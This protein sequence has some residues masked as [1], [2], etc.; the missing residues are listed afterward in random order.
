MK[1]YSYIDSPEMASVRS[2][3]RI[4]A[5][6]ISGMYVIAYNLIFLF[7]SPDKSLLQLIGV[8]ASYIFLAFAGFFHR[9]TS[10]PLLALIALQITSLNLTFFGPNQDVSATGSTAIFLSAVFGIT[11]LNKKWVPAWIALNVI[12]LTFLVIKIGI[13]TQYFGAE[14][15]LRTFSVVQLIVVAVWFHISWFRQ[16]EYVKARDALNRRMADS[17]ESALELQERTRKWRE[18]LVHT[19]ET[20]LNDIRSVI[21][22][23]D[24]DFDELKKQ[25]INRK[26]HTPRPQTTETNFSDLM[27]EVQEYVSLQID[28]NITGAGTEIPHNVYVALRSVIVELCRNFERHANATKITSKASLIYGILRIELFHNGKDSTTTFDTGIGQGIVI[29]ETLDEINAK[30]FRRISGVE[31][32]VALNMRQASSRTLGST[33]LGRISVSSVTVGNAV[34]G[35]LFSLSLL[36]HAFLGEQ[37]AGLCTL[38]LALFAAVVNWKR[39]PINRTYIIG[40]ALVSIIQAIATFNSISET[41]SIDL[42]AIN[43]VLAGFAVISIL[44]W[45]D[46]VKLWVAGLPW[47]IGLIAFRTQIDAETSGTAISSLNTGYG[48]PAF[49]AA[50]VFGIIRGNQRLKETE[51]LSELEIKERV[52]ASAVADLAR[53][54]DSAINDA[55]NILLDIAKEKK[56][57]IANKNSLRRTDSLIRAIIQVDPKTSGGFSKAALEIVRHAHSVGTQIKVLM[58]RDQGLLLEISEELLNELKEIVQSAR[59]NKT[60]IQVL[61]NSNSSI[62]VLKISSSTASRVNLRKL[63]KLEIEGVVIKTEKS[64]DETIIFVE[65]LQAV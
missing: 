5:L 64:E 58:V 10:A 32:S 34:G 13:P 49:A 9:W 23:K 41:D 35:I 54:L 6:I 3:T 65:Q 40:V 29:R 39:V 50:A 53:E 47:L 28:L 59:D 25:I 21:D 22:S 2:A 12:H 46:S 26:K 38:S 24:I 48:L 60:V 36:Q 16:L 7:Y 51:D 56:I 55:T 1:K 43:S 18:L 33:D 14:L 4:T 15:P 52:A 17:R 30:L 37:V 8:F 20:V 42:L 19:H 45:V 31:L 11:T 44:A 62:L 27:A 63:K 61:A 57:S